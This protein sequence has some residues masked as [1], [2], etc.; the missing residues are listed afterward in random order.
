MKRDFVKSVDRICESVAKDN[1]LAEGTL[2][3]VS[4]DGE[5]CLFAI[6]EA[7]SI[8]GTFRIPIRQVSTAKIQ[9]NLRETL[10]GAVPNTATHAL[11]GGG[12]DLGEEETDEGLATTT[13]LNK[14]NDVGQIDQKWVK[15]K[16]LAQLK[17]P[18]V[19]EGAEIKPLKPIFDLF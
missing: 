1:L 9:A 5:M 3:L 6:S 2:R 11:T 19:T 10:A 18:P 16:Y 12:A 15:T 14:D 17:E 7:R 4:V 8:I 13:A